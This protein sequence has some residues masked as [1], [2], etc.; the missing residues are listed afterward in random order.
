MLA[1]TSFTA[2]AGKS[3][4]LKWE[5][6]VPDGYDPDAL[7]DEYREKYGIDELPDDHP[8]NYRAGGTSSRHAG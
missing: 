3:A 8:K 2:H 6:L 5:D 4:E 7:V 1:I